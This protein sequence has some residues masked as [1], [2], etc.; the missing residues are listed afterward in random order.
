[1]KINKNGNPI[2]Y[3]RY[4]EPHLL[5]WGVDYIKSVVSYNNEE[6]N[7]N[8]NKILS[9]SDSSSFMSFFDFFWKK[10]DVKKQLYGWYYWQLLELSIENYPIAYIWLHGW[11]YD[12]VEVTGMW[13]T[14]FWSDFFYEILEFFWLKFEKYKRIDICF[15][16]DIDINYVYN[17]VLPEKYKANETNEINEEEKKNQLKIKP[18]LGPSGLETLDIWSRDKKNNKYIFKRIYNKKIDSKKKKKQALYES[19]HNTE[20]VTRFELEIREELASFYPV[21]ICKDNDALF[22]IVVKH[23]FKINWGF[24]GRLLP[25]NFA[26]VTQKLRDEKK[27]RKNQIIDGLDVEPQSAHE[28]KLKKTI[29]RLK[30]EQQYGTDFI[31]EKEIKQWKATTIAYIKRLIKNWYKITIEDID[32]IYIEKV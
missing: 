28:N 30:N 10:I 14:F 32:N 27:E 11:Y 19:V 7:E 12:M 5:Y 23:F 3:G 24:F 4:K 6:K 1:M 13:L 8:L 15:D 25:E 2:K 31:Q 22:F 29:D 16:I 20:Y 26:E 21:W 17:K 9:L 18:R